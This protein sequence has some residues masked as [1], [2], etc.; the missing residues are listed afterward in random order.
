MKRERERV[1]EEKEKRMTKSL[2]SS[3]NH[4]KVKRR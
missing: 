3:I 2:V 1:M 4:G